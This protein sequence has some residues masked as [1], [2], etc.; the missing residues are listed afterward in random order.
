MFIAAVIAFAALDI[1]AAMNHCGTDTDHTVARRAT[2][3]RVGM[4]DSVC[5]W[6]SPGHA[7]LIYRDRGN[8]SG[9]EPILRYGTNTLQIPRAS[10]SAGG[11]LVVEVPRARSLS[12]DPGVKSNVIIKVGRV[13]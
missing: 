1:S 13:L 12:I 9:R 6:T 10:W 8:G 4:T 5:D 2:G 7:V 11:A 3:E